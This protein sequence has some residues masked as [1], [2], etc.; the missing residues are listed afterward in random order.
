MA[1]EQK[2]TYAIFQGLLTI[3]LLLFFYYQKLDTSWWGAKFG[4]LSG[5][6]VAL[7]V[8]I[9]LAP[10]ERLGKNLVQALLLLTDVVLASLTLYW[11]Q[12]PRSDLYL[13]Y[14]IIILG[15]ALLRNLSQ[16]F[17]VA[18]FATVFYLL[19][20]WQPQQGLPEEAGFWLR[21][22]FLW[23]M[24]FLAGILSQDV[25]QVH[26]EDE[27]AYRQ[28][29]LD[30][31]RLA[32]MGRLAGEMVH[33]IKGPLTSIQVN[34]ETMLLRS[35]QP[36]SPAEAEEI[37]SEVLHC[38]EILKGLLKAG[39]VED[40]KLEPLDLGECVR[41]ALRTARAVMVRQK[42][43]LK[44]T[45]L[46]R[47]ARIIGDKMLL[48]EA[49]S[50][51]VQNA[52]EAMPQGGTLELGI[53][54]VRKAAWWA[55]SGESLDFFELSVRDSGQG[56]DPKLMGRIFEPFFSTKS[57]KGGTGLGLCAALRILQN[58]SGFI[59]AHS[60]GPRRGAVF[61]VSIPRFER[62]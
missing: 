60:A 35:K 40:T 13:A 42:V 8:F 5:A 57:D 14:F 24:A 59:E 2:R 48:Q 43:R 33:R 23:V 6:L 20:S 26:A 3:L 56:I 27:K 18:L 19:S 37:R 7:L 39:R 47:R 12:N 52:L 31:E 32:T 29:L 11:S 46:G 54:P 36:G 58:H 49:V 17:L 10:V 34:A 45:G 4:L 21:I 38:S 61:V 22:P 51:L 55:E 1:P 15:A 16:C 25:Q 30:M 62:V 41:A 9:R 44:M 50:A 28:K 53:H